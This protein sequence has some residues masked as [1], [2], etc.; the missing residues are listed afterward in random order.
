MQGTTQVTSSIRLLLVLLSIS[1]SLLA[2]GRCSTLPLNTTRTS[3]TIRRGESKI[4]VL[5]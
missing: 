3:T 4:D 5:E 2:S 1:T